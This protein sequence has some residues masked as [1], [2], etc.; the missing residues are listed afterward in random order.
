[1]PDCPVPLMG[2]DTVNKLQAQITFGKGQVKMH[3]SENK[4]VEA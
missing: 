3:T 1:M 2:R 4:T